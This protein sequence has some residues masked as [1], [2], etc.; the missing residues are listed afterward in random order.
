M[1]FRLLIIRA[2]SLKLSKYGFLTALCA[3]PACTRSL[4]QYSS[5]AH[6]SK[7]A[8]EVPGSEE[9]SLG[10]PHSAPS[11]ESRTL[12][13]SFRAV[14]SIRNTSQDKRLSAQTPMGQSDRIAPPAPTRASELRGPDCERSLKNLGVQ[15]TTLTE[16]KGVETPVEIHGP[17]G[18]IE[19]WAND[20]RKLQLDCRLALALESLAPIFSQYRISQARYSGAYAYRRTKSGRLSHHALGLA[21]DIHALSFSGT[22]QE[23]HTNFTRNIG[24][25]AANPQLNQFVCKLRE[26]R[27]FEEFLTPDYNDDHRDHL[28]ISVP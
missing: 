27:L 7:S 5:P 13:H 12:L 2:F 23:V 22:S 1:A 9:D 21:I 6:W 4:P 14:P 18:G 11:A 24:C 17:L 19:F 3:L 25:R 15:F 10:T 8:Y 28:H 20:G 16:L 26:S